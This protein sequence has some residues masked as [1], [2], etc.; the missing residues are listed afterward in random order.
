MG[1]LN[2]LQVCNLKEPG[3]NHDGDGLLLEV[4]PG[5]SKSWVARLQANGKRRDY[6]LGSLKDVSLTEARDKARDYRKQLR[7][8]N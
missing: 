4:R 8:G 3:R 7:A 2:P 5:G 6:G 1:K